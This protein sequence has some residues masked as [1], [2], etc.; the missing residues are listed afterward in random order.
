MITAIVR[1]PLSPGTALDSSNAL[2]ARSAPQY[3]AAP[4]LIRKN[5]LFGEDGGKP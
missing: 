3:R 4:G 5:Y 2:F 1:F